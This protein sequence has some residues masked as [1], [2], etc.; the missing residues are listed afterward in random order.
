MSLKSKKSKRTLSTLVLLITILS[1]GN[2]YIPKAEAITAKGMTKEIE[3]LFQNFLKTQKDIYFKVVSMKGTD[4]PV[5]LISDS[6]MS[7]K[8]V[9][10]CDI[11]IVKTVKKNA[12]NSY[13]LKKAGSIASTSTAY[14]IW[15]YENKLI[16][17]SHHYTGFAEIKNN[18]LYIN[19]YQGNFDKK[20]N[21]TFY[22]L[23]YSGNKCISEKKINSSE[24]EKYV[25]KTW[26]HQTL[27]NTLTFY[28]N[29]KNNRDKYI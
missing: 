3:A 13:K 29:A 26:E 25:Y 9:T 27:K 8:A 7:N 17:G 5:L 6:R 23:I 2:L 19:Y 15:K 1:I 22:H 14:D 21:E 28:K 24:G 11:Y 20:G 4:K 12:A 10:N 18:K 16:Y